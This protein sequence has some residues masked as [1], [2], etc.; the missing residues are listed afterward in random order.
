MLL[1]PVLLHCS[2]AAFGFYLR[3]QMCVFMSY[4]HPS[5]YVHLTQL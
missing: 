3:V 5:L 1:L 4:V 2:A